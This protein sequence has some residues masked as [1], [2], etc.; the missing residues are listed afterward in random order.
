M[1]AAVVATV[2]RRRDSAGATRA[3]GAGMG[4]AEATCRLRL[5]Q[6]LINGAL[7]G[8]A[9]LGGA[10]VDVELGLVAAGVVA[11]VLL[12]VVRA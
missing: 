4:G 6:T 2:Q 12:A 1:V 8:R 10:V 11:G 7:M 5:V 3:V 9:V